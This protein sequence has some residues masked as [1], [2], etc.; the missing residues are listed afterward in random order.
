MWRD[1]L[2]PGTTA[3]ASRSAVTSHACTR[4]H[5]PRSRVQKGRPV[6]YVIDVRKCACARTVWKR[7]RADANLEDLPRYG[8]SSTTVRLCRRG[9]GSI[10][11]QWDSHIYPTRKGISS[12]QPLAEHAVGM[13]ELRDRCGILLIDSSHVMMTSSTSRATSSELGTSRDGECSPKDSSDECVELIR[14]WRSPGFR[15]F[16]SCS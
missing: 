9:N 14:F 13:T 10:A 8:F 1:C 15:A 7:S 3:M 16:V 5:V 4:L 2:A 6:R 11:G 12:S